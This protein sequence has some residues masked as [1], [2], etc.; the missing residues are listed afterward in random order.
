MDYKQI[1]NQVASVQHSSSDVQPECELGF[2]LFPSIPIEHRLA[3]RNCG[4]V[5]PGSIEDYITR[6]KGYSGLD[7]ALKR[8]REDILDILVSSG[9]KDKAGLIADRLRACQEAEGEAR[10]IVCKAFDGDPGSRAARCLLYYDVHAVL[11]GLLICLYASGASQGILCLDENNAALEELVTKAVQQMN[12]YGLL[13]ERILD[14]EFSAAIEIR[15]V[16]ASPVMS[17][18]TALLRFLEGRQALPYLHDTSVPLQMIANPSV[19]LEAEILALV[20]GIVQHGIEWF[21]NNG[22]EACRG[23]KIITINDHETRRVVEVPFGT[24]V[25]SLL[26]DTG[27]SGNGQ[28]PVRMVQFGGITGAFYGVDNLD[29]PVICNEARA[30]VITVYRGKGRSVK[31]VRDVM[32][33]LRTQSCGQCVFCREGTAQMAIILEELLQGKAQPADIELLEELS[34]LMSQSCI[35]SFGL[36]A[37]TPFISSLRE[38]REDYDSCFKGGNTSR[39]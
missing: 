23:T 30:S 18:E 8:S 10:Y 35:C 39:G 27:I 21:A 28:E 3:L 2:S 29:A 20:S 19:V 15:S 6:T 25:Q 17:E 37:A 1:S 11:E 4:V 32:E 13:G 9:L 31:T 22:V 12:D 5:A 7:T 16:S 26:A 38:F 36:Q 33:Y 14:R 24:T 34:A